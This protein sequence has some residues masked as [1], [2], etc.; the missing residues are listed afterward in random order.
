VVPLH[1]QIQFIF[2]GSVCWAVKN[3][4]TASNIH[5]LFEQGEDAKNRLLEMADVAL[6]P[7]MA[8]SGTCLKVL[9][10]MAAGST[11]LATEIGARGIAI[12]NGVSGVVCPLDEISSAL[13]RLTSD[14]N[15]CHAMGRKGAEIA[16][17]LYDWEI[18][19]KPIIEALRQIMRR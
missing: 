18:A 17:K 16:R 19:A 14:L 6:N 9:D 7:L 15:A 13:K 1:P 3:E 10:Y 11:V 2:I 8:G 5:L 4:A 12:E